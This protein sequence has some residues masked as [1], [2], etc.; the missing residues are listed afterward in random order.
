MADSSRSQNFSSGG[1]VHQESE[2]SD[3]DFK[4]SLGQ[5]RGAPRGPGI[6]GPWHG[7]SDSAILH[8]P[9]QVEMTEV[10]PECQDCFF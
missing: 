3:G 4:E 5:N 10:D 1:D 8:H 7:G 2:N 9:S 6:D